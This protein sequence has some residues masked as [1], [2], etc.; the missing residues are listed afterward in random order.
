M[1]KDKNDPRDNVN[2]SCYL[3]NKFNSTFPRISCNSATT[4]EIDKI[5]KSL[6]NKISVVI[7]KFSPKNPNIKC[8]SYRFPL[9]LDL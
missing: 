7:M 8:P 6:K 4:Y 1:D 3:M 5:I 2:T 9:S